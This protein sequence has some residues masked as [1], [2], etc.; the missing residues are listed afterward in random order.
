M[1]DE[2]EIKHVNWTEVFSFTRIFKSCK[3]ALHV[4]KMTLALAA[5]VLVFIFGWG[6]DRIWSIGNSYV[7]PG[8]IMDHCGKSDAAFEADKEGFEKGRLNEAVTLK[9]QTMLQFRS[10]DVYSAKLANADLRAA[11][12][13]AARK[14]NDDAKTEKVTDLAQMQKQAKKDKVSWSRILSDAE[15]TFKE[16]LS[17]IDEALDKAVPNAKTTI[18]KMEIT[19]E[20][21]TTLIAEVEKAAKLAIAQKT[22]LAMEFQAEVD[23]VR[24]KPIFASFRAYEVGWLENALSAVRQGNITGGLTAYSARMDNKDRTTPPAVDAVPLAAVENAPGF[25]VCLLMC[26]QGFAWLFSEHWVFAALLTAFS[27]GVWALFGG[28]IYRVAALHAAREEKISIVHA[29]KFSIDK[30]ASFVTAPLLPVAIILVLALVMDVLVLLMNVPYLSA[31]YGLFVGALFFVFLLMG[32]AAAFLLAGLVGGGA[33]MYPTI[34]VEGSDSF[35]AISRSFSY[36]L[37]R[38]WRAGLYGL[39]ALVYGTITYLVVR[40]FV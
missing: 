35:D 7:R 38:P 30:F 3:M 16:E 24:G 32:L 37:S 39:V 36:V 10:P 2:H 33:L 8:E 15:K 31:I 27:L 34:A 18:N 4:S 11:F 9:Y 21:K 13:D 29:L 25:L 28:A 40:L 1:A 20:E 26:V 19:T 22:R 6:L 12:N 17:R 5:I 23:K 14:I